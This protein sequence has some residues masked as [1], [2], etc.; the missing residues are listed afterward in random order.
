M[1]RA[2]VTMTSSTPNVPSGTVRGD[3]PR[4]HSNSETNV[5]NERD[6]VARPAVQD[7]LVGEGEV[8]RRDRDRPSSVNAVLTSGRICRRRSLR[9]ASGLGE[10]L[11]R[12]L[13]HR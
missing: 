12:V 8:G 2:V 6:D 3:E 1:R 4:G 7:D 11:T 5:R 13:L 9:V 10:L